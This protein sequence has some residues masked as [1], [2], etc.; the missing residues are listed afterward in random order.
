[1]K[2]IT[3]TNLYTLCIVFMILI[4]FSLSARSTKTSEKTLS[5]SSKGHTGVD[6]AKTEISAQEKALNKEAI[7]HKAREASVKKEVK[8][9]AEEAA[10]I[11][12]EVDKKKKK[13]EKSRSQTEATAKKADSNAEIAATK[14]EASAKALE[15]STLKTKEQM[16]ELAQAREEGKADA[17]AIARTEAE[18]KEKKNKKAKKNVK[19]EKKINRRIDA[20]VAKR[21]AKMPMC[22]GKGNGTGGKNGTKNRLGGTDVFKGKINAT[23]A[24][25][26]V[27]FTNWSINEA[28]YKVERCDQILLIK[29]KKLN[30]DNYCEKTDAFMTMS[31]YMINFFEKKDVKKLIDSYSMA[32]ITNIP[33]EIAGSPGCTMWQTKTKSFP[34]CYE[35]REILEQITAAYYKFLD[36]KNPNANKVAYALSRNCDMAKMN[37]TAAGPFGE[38]GPMYKDILMAQDPSLFATKEQDLTGVNPYYISHD[39]EARPPGDHAPK[40][41][42]LFNKN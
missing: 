25:G 30:L 37:L 9:N 19:K 41:K 5:G 1:M 20:E 26:I 12:A 23:N 15:K 17:I 11:Q 28:P 2:I 3:K 31:I 6:A 35:S 13:E 29:G 42:N 39:G 21:L 32:D 38:M 8:K 33:T 27:G 10:R 22:A 40:P 4:N 36:C 14:L 24:I 16:K 34:F 18:V 7:R